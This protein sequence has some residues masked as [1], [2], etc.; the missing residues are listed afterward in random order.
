MKT[1]RIKIGKGLNKICISRII[2]THL[3]GESHSKLHRFTVGVSIMVVGV[4]ITK[5]F[6]GFHSVAIHILSDVLGYGLHGIGLIPFADAFIS[7]NANKKLAQNET[8]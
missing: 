4:T 7:I 1:I 5:A 6:L 2:C 8:K 3:I